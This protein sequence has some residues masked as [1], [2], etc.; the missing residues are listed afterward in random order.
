MILLHD[1][2][3]TVDGTKQCSMC[4]EK[5][6][7]Q[8][9][10]EVNKPSPIH[11]QLQHNKGSLFLHPLSTSTGQNDRYN[12]MYILYFMLISGNLNLTNLAI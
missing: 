4:V 1:S 9:L 2:V 5:A 11:N 6:A 12:N 3:L 8:R 10:E 7:K